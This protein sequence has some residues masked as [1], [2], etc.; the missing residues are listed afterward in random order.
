MRSARFLL[1][2]LVPS[3][4]LL[5]G[6]GALEDDFVEPVSLR[7]VRSGSLLLKTS[8]PG[9]FLPAPGLSTDVSLQV[10]GLVARARVRQRF[11]NPTAQWVEGV[12]AF[13]LPEDAAVDQLRMVAGERVIEGEIHERAEAKKIYEQA[14]REG[15]KAS[16]LE[17]ER[18]NLFTTSVANLGPGETIEVEI[19]YQQELR[20]DHGRFQL[21]FPMVVAPRY[22]PGGASP[23]ARGEAGIDPAAPALDFSGHGWAAPSR[24]V[25]DARRITPHAAE[26]GGKILNPVEL[27]LT[28]DAGLPLA[29]TALPTACSCRSRRAVGIW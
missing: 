27:E 11:E 8:Q 17:Q 3:L 25:P 14:K 4:F 10:T 18:P 2:I 13:P 9:L 22:I 16:L 12:Y 28:L 6:A 21:R 15:K 23:V 7:Q 19:E 26:T 1:F 5:P 29:S 20:Y 24:Q